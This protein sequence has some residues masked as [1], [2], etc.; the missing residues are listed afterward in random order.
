MSRGKLSADSPENWGGTRVPML[1][2]LCGWCQD[3]LILEQE[4]YHRGCRH[5]TGYYDKLWVCGCDC[6]ADWVPQAVTV[7]RG[8]KILESA[9]EPLPRPAESINV[10]FQ[11]DQAARAAKAEKAAQRGRR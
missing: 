8:G 10:V 4:S 2:T 5:E 11:R 3:A 9:T 6:N 7:E 1:S